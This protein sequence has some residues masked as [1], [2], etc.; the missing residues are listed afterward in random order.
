MIRFIA[1]Y[2]KLKADIISIF[3]FIS[4]LRQRKNDV[5]ENINLKTIEQRMIERKE[6][7]KQIHEIP[8][9]IDLIN[10]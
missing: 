3:E 9:L 7:A 4:S 6:K 5:I 2:N 1:S 8:N 10:A